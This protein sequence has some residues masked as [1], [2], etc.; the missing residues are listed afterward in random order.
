MFSKVWCNSKKE[1]FVPALKAE[2]LVSLKMLSVQEPCWR[3]VSEV[4]DVRVHGSQQGL[5]ARE[6]W[7]YLNFYL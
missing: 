5:E 6:A 4:F 3:Q 7:W 1:S 2:L